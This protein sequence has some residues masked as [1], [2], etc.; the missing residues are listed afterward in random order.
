MLLDIKELMHL[1]FFYYGNY[2]L[3]L[4]YLEALEVYMYI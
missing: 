3:I 4:E 1:L 2:V